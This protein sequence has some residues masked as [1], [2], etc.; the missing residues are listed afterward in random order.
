M[1][2]RLHLGLAI[3][4]SGAGGGG[5]ALDQR[6]IG[7]DGRGRGVAGEPFAEQVARADQPAGAVGDGDR[8]AGGVGGG[9]RH[10]PVG[11]GITGGQRRGV[12][13]AIPGE[14]R[15]DGDDR[16]G[17]AG[18]QRPVANGIEDDRGGGGRGEREQGHE[19]A[20][21]G[22]PHPRLI[23]PIYPRDHRRRPLKPLQ[24]NHDATDQIRAISSNALL[25]VRLPI[26]NLRACHLRPMRRRQNQSAPT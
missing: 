4:P 16:G 2:D 18:G 8:H 19:A 7:I 17:K 22:L 10:G 6:G 26:L 21:R 25:S 1:G 9:A 20:R 14:Q 23:I 3:A 5:Q 15:G 11:H 12:E 13:A 24:W